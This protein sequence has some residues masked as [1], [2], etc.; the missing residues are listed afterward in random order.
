MG[1]GENEFI[2]RQMLTQ[3]A[4]GAFPQTHKVALNGKNIASNTANVLT[5]VCVECKNV[6]TYKVL[7]KKL[8]VSCLIIWK[9]LTML[10]LGHK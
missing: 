6:Q 4:N 3:N 1:L 5:K 8:Q 7:Q 10:S 9:T 2:L